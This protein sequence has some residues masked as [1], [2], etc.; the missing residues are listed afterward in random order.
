MNYDEREEIRRIIKR[1]ETEFDYDH[2]WRDRE[3]DLKTAMKDARKL[4]RRLEEALDEEWNS[5]FFFKR[6]AEEAALQ[7]LKDT[8]ALV[9]VR[10]EESV[11][12]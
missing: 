11:P 8:G 2:E 6:N 10:N 3:P 1:L 4:V 7:L 12:L 9:R 5:G